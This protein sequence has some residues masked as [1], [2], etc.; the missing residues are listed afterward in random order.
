MVM[1]SGNVVC[2][3]VSLC[4]YF[5]DNWGELLEANHIK[6]FPQEGAK[7]RISWLLV[8]DG[9]TNGVVVAEQVNR[10]ACS[11]IPP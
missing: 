11:D 3:D 2:Q 4:V 6:E 9:I 10:S 7:I 5:P 8:C 1:S